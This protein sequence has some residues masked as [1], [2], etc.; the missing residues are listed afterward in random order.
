MNVPSRNELHGYIDA[1]QECN[2]G[3]VKDII[4]SLAEPAPI[5]GEPLVIETNL[6]KR[7]KK[8]V[9]AGRRERKEHP[10]NFTSWAD[11][12]K[13]LGIVTL[14]AQGGEG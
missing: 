9:A 12:K 4:S 7:E 2:F 5:I 6:T 13:E 14:A 3:R 10:E 8:I 11:V 1:I